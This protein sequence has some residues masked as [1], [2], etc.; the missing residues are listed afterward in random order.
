[1]RVVC[2]DL[3]ERNYGAVV[4]LPDGG[5]C[6]AGKGAEFD[7]PGWK[8]A[9]ITGKLPAIVWTWSY[10]LEMRRDSRSKEDVLLMLAPSLIM[11][12]FSMISCGAGGQ[13]LLCYVSERATY[14]LDFLWELCAASS[15]ST[16]YVWKGLD[17]LFIALT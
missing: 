2:N 1:M 10:R 14:Y 12:L 5:V 3:V 15:V 17:I 16:C 11:S 7:K 9:E 13:P 8:Q 4:G 6:E